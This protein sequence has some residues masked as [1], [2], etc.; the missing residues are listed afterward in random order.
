MQDTYLQATTVQ[1]SPQ[2]LNR[3]E[4]RYVTPELTQE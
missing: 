4:H 2:A 3:S 1:K